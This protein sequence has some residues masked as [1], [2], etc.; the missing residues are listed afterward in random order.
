VWEGRRREASPYPDH[1]LETFTEHNRMAQEKLRD[2]IWRFYRDLLAYRT[3]P[4][5]KR[6]AALRTRF[7]RIFKRTT[8]FVSLDRL[9]KRLRANK[10]ELL[11]VLDRP[12]IPLHTNGSENDI[13][14]QVTKRKIS[15]GT[16]SD[17][18]RDCRDAFLGLAK[19]CAKLGIAFWDF[20]GA[21]LD[22]LNQIAIPA[23]PDL[24]RDQVLNSS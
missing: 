9:L 22:I 13:R 20:L 2:L 4:S 16:R 21:R 7:D 24:V 10:P 17:Q 3:D 11:R 5:P 8:G 15:G 14:C 12:E 1:K 6:K 18:G 19:T 23:L